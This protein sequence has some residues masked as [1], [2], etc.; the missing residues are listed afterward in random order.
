MKERYENLD[1]LRAYLYREKI[2]ELMNYRWLVVIATAG[3]VVG[4]YALKGQVFIWLVLC[5]LL[6]ILGI[7]GGYSEGCISEQSC[8]LS[9]QHKH[10]DLPLP[11]VC[12]Q[13]V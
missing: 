13:G 11:Y 7:L 9:C 6:T 8:A 3:A 12:V 4:I 5:S 1:G 10:G 2:R